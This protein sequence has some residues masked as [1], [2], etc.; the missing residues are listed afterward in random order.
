MFSQLS[1]VF[2]DDCE[3]SFA[4]QTSFTCL[5]HVRLSCYLR[6]AAHWP[7]WILGLIQWNN[8]IKRLQDTNRTA[9]EPGFE[10]FTLLRCNN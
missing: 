3:C 1:P 10:Y 7:V 4:A 5:G 2:E 8:A 9:G 6:I